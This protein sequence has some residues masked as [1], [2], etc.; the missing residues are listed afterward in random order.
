[1]NKKI[2]ILSITA[3]IL[4]AIAGTAWYFYG[5]NKSA[6]DEGIGGFISN[7]FPSSGD[8]DINGNLFPSGDGGSAGY[9]ENENLICLVQSAVSGL[10][11][12]STSIRYIEKATGHIF[13]I[14]PDGQNRN[15]I[16]NTTI[17]KSFESFWAPDGNSLIIR[18]LEDTGNYFIARNFSGSISKDS[19]EGIFLPNDLRVVAVSPEENK[20]FYLIPSEDINIGMTAS[21]FNEKKKQVMAVP[22][23]EF[24]ISWPSQNII[25]FVT[26]PSNEID[27]YLYFLNLKT[28]SFDKI[29]GNTRGLTALVSPDAGKIFYN[30]SFGKRISAKIFDAIKKTETD[31]GLNA[32]SDKC[33][34]SKKDKAVIYCG[35]PNSL[36]QADY[37]DDWY[38]G[39]VSF[40][41]SV[42]KINFDKGETTLVGADTG[43]DIIN[44]VLTPDEN[45]L[46]FINKKDN[47][48]WSLKLK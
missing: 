37:P 23:G 44:P 14:N 11:V 4:L 8:R 7:F 38:Q 36:P 17:L 48:L 39:L 12:A 20:I 22:F 24:N 46:V 47:T 43:I 29:I 10:S 30:Q 28:G 25:S 21:F 16:S 18:Y 3:I 13:E 41:D 15:R 1:M 6:S 5:R 32:F 19:L 45:Y 9:S 26:K 2:L 34:W 35:A 42:W 33:V 31:F 27:G 40:N